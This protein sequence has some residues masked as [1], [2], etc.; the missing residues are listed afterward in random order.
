MKIFPNGLCARAPWTLVAI[1]ALAL[2]AGPVAAQEDEAASTDTE[3]TS[4][5]DEYQSGYDDIPQFGGPDGVSA[6]LQRNDELRTGTYG[7]QGMQ[8]AFAPYF[9][10]KRWLIEE[11]GVSFGL[12][13][14]LLGQYATESQTGADPRYR[15]ASA[16]YSGNVSARRAQRTP[17][18][19][20]RFGLAGE[21][22]AAVAASAFTSVTRLGQAAYAVRVAAE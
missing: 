2:T 11:Y 18:D 1:G 13:M 14:Y 12:Q 6:E 19:S 8:R 5:D 16:E 20:T 7:F 15:P 17:S 4:E 22:D 10:W 9:D 21:V 3:E